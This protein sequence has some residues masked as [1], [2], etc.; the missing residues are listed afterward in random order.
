[1]AERLRGRAGQ[2]QRMKRLRAEP[3]CRRCA[4]RGRVIASTVPDHIKPLALGGSDDESNIRCICAACHAE[5]T[6]EQFEQ[7]RT[8]GA[9][10]DGWPDI[11]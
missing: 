7:R 1:M 5:V 2:R 4:E 9:D 11:A 6:T 3:L 10:A 8:V